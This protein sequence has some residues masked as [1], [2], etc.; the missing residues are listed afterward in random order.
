MTFDSIQSATRNDFSDGQ[1][2][3][4]N[5]EFQGSLQVVPEPSEY[6]MMFGAG[7]FAF[8]LWRKRRARLAAAA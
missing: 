5:F 7:V 2:L 4:G 3:Y 1:Y 8:G 6:A